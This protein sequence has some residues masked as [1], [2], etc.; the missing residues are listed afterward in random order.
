MKVLVTGGAGFIGSHVVDE[1]LAEGY[2]VVVV[3]DLST[4]RRSNLNPDVKLYQLDIRSQELMEV[5]EIERP[6]YVN[7]HAAQMDVRRS[8]VEPIFDA[9][10]NILGSINLIE[11]ARKSQ[12]KRFIYISTGGAVYG[13]PEYLPCDE[14]HPIA[15]IC[16]YG[17]S[18]HTVEHYLYMYHENYGLDYVVLRYPNV[19]GPRQ[20]PHGEAGVVAIFTG[21]MLAGDQVVINGDGEQQ[22]DF[23]YVGDCA[24]A[25][26][27][28]TTT[29]NGN[30]IY[31]IGFGRPTS[32]NEIFTVLKSITKYE[33]DPVHGPAKLGETRRIY[34]DATKA[35]SELGWTPTV[36][37]EEGL[38]QTVAYF[39]QVERAQS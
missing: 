3:D 38:E 17:A 26:L 11:C 30:T 9:D 12:V 4:G 39:N 34:L 19:Y 37:L 32:V 28:A 36:T 14:S 7:H 25:N 24:R 31:N 10:V 23:V 29:E 2:E 22:R 18:K 35:R 6:D 5:F 8:V 1:Y 16:Q 15:P 21:Q 20:D 13:E 33:R 27:L